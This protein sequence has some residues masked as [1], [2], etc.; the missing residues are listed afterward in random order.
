MKI[1]VADKISDRG[2]HLLQEQP[3]W[4]VVLA[5]KDSLN[6]EIADADALIVRSA[7]KVT[8]EWL[9]RGEKLRAVGRA[10]VGVD[11]IDLDEA[12]K[13]GVLVMS[14]PGGSSVSVAEHTFALL[15]GLVRQLP[16][17]D[18]A[19]REGRWEKSASGAEVRGKTLG[20]VG[21]GRIGSEVAWR[22][23]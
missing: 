21:L 2:V 18:A 5:T 20:L 15:L 17:L 4:N 12:T 6:A 9:D 3:G 8:A 14:T 19:M 10:G 16:R 22:A 23:E 13:R 11:N 7:T 1:V